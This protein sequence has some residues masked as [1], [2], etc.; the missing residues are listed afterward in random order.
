M[1]DWLIFFCVAALALVVLGPRYGLVARWR[2]ARRRAAQVRR[3]DAIKHILKC[4]VNGGEA[5]IESLAGHLQIPTDRTAGVLENLEDR[6]LLSLEGGRLRLKDAGRDLG[7][8]LIRAHRLWESYLSEQTGIAESEWHKRAERQEHL[9]SPE[10]ADALAAR[11]GNPTLDPHGDEIPAR[12]QPVAGDPGMPLNVAQT[13][14][15][16]RVLHI[17]DEPP[18][19]YAQIT[20][21]GIRP[22]MR[23]F[24]IEKLPHRI[25]FWADGDE[26]VLAPVVA[27]NISVQLLTD[28]TGK[29]L[30]DEEYLSGLQTG[31]SGRVL[32][33][34]PAC[35]GPERRRLLDLGFV[36]GTDVVAEMRSPGGGPTAYRVRGT[37]IALRKE[38]AGLIRVSSLPATS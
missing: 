26:H 8:H 10:Q 13:N 24:I 29:D 20:A 33:L 19:V 2:A 35:R 21:L 25:R 7:L 11:L 18:A 34:S 17:E 38:Q 27:N 5:T 32:G 14:Q 16:L 1:S 12:G 30:L 4:E 3:E 31:Q 28:C 6:G 15:P 23:G 22:E 36:P 9:L 37:L